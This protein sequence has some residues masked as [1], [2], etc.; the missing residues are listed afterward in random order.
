MK[1]FIIIFFFAIAFIAIFLSST[2]YAGRGCCSWH[3][4]EAGCSSSGR[5]ICADGTL[6]PSC[7]CYYVAPFRC[8]IEGQTYTSQLPAKSKY[9]SMVKEAVDD[10]YQNLLGRTGN[11]NDYNYWQSKMPYNDCDFTIA[12]ST[13]RSEV[14]V[15]EEREQYLAKQSVPQETIQPEPETNTDESY[16]FWSEWGGIVIVFGF[17]GI[18]ALIA[19]ISDLSSKRK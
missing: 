11:Q 3:G 12:P 15:S 17:W 5:T 16:D 18:I 7:T 1:K 13:I 9:L 8:T 19:W 14:L 2:A 6:S 10:V 4:G